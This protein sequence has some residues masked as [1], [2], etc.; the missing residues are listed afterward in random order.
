M[1]PGIVY[2]SRTDASVGTM[3]CIIVDRRSSGVNNVYSVGYTSPRQ[4]FTPW[5]CRAINISIPRPSV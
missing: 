1:D 3:L 5:T 2:Q 4:L